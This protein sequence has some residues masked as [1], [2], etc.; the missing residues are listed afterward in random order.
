MW[1]IHSIYGIL[2]SHTDKLWCISCLEIF[3][4]L[5]LWFLNVTRNW[6]G[7]AHAHDAYKKSHLHLMDSNILNIHELQVY[8][9]KQ[10]RSRVVFRISEYD[11][12]FRCGIC[13]RKY[14]LDLI[15]FLGAAWKPE[16][17]WHRFSTDGNLQY[18]NFRNCV[19]FNFLI[20]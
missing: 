18:T 20:T 14:V 10:F 3:F 1:G 17:G 6:V 13:T 12:S 19:V 7:L 15:P 4:L 16:S 11:T 2:T 8:L 9:L 5:F